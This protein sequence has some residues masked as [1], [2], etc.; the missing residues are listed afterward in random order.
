MPSATVTTTTTQEVKLKPQVK[1]KLL[2]ELRAYAQ[3]KS[4][5]DALDHAMK[6]H[7]ASI[8]ELMETTG[9]SSLSV[10]GFKTTLVAPVKRTLDRKRLR[11]A[12]VTEAQ[13][14]AGT[15]ETPTKPYIKV[16]VPGSKEDG[17][18]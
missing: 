15:I 16:T 1:R 18:E 8:E 7:K 4:E 13:L 14:D 11:M 3:L 5:R 6:G 12:G 9:E 2:T 10:E 17:D